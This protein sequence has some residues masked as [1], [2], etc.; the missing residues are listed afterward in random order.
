MQ[1]VTQQHMWLR[2]GCQTCQLTAAK[3]VKPDEASQR[4][5][6]KSRVA[7]KVLCLRRGDEGGD[8]TSGSGDTAAGRPV[9]TSG[10]CLPNAVEVLQDIT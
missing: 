5:S 3:A 9:D 8:I 7:P 4:A 10:R 1:C 6:M 2:I